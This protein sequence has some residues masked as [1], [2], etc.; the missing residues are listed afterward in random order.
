MTADLFARRFDAIFCN[1]DERF[2]RF[3]ECKGVASPAAARR[4]DETVSAAA[5]WNKR[6]SLDGDFSRAS[7]CEKRCSCEEADQNRAECAGKC[8]GTSIAS[9]INAACDKFDGTL[10]LNAAPVISTEKQLRPR[11]P[12]S[13]PEAAPACNYGY[14]RPS[15]ASTGPHKLKWTDDARFRRPICRE[16]S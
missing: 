2:Q 8:P 10:Q 15:I 6:Q 4:E 12:T 14:G 7:T 9:I 5:T 3:L 1:V 16:Y 11:P 13:E